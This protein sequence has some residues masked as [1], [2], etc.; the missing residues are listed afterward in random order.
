MDTVITAITA[1][2]GL[3]FSVAVGI[4]VEEVIFGEIF[5]LFFAEPA[6]VRVRS[7]TRAR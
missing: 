2:A 1:I 4:L 6:V 5:R 7:W 3:I